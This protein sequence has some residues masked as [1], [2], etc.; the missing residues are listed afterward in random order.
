MLSNH[1]ALPTF[2]LQS[3]GFEKNKVFTVEEEGLVS[4]SEERRRVKRL[5]KKNVCD[6]CIG[7]AMTLV[8]V[9]IM[10]MMTMMRMLMMTMTMMVKKNVCDP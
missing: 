8:P 4:I 5:E 2:Y 7:P 10:T 1:S 6:R 9:K 3:A